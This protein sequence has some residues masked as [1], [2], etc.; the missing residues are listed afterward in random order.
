MDFIKC[1]A[2]L[3]RKFSECKKYKQ[4]QWN[5]RSFRFEICGFLIHCKKFVPKNDEQHSM[6]C[7]S[8]KSEG[9]FARK[10]STSQYVECV[11][12]LTRG[13]SMNQN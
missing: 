4:E 6:E 9:M 5:I 10:I 8:G 13:E 7:F 11:Y 1:K 3:K 12:T 2:T